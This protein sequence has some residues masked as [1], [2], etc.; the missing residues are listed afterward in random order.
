MPLDWVRGGGH[1]VNQLPPQPQ[2]GLIVMIPPET[3]KSELGN[4]WGG[5]GGSD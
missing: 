1:E 3:Q 2:C 4:Y 5:G